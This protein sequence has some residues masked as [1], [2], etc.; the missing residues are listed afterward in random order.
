MTEKS[1]ANLIAE[2]QKKSDVR[3]GSFS[4]VARPVESLSTSNLAIDYVT[5]IGGLPV[6]RLIELYGL[7]SSGK[8]TTS[9]QAAAALQQDIIKSG[10]EEYILYLDFEHSLDKMYSQAL[11]LDSEHKSFILVQPAWVEDGAEIALS[12]IETGQVRL[13]IWDSVAAM[14]PKALGEGDFDQRTSAMNRARLMAGLLQRLT[15][16]LYD[17]G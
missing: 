16:L 8:S 5:G 3:I 1:V 2:I 13:S 15:A 14:T 6:G 4:D 17:H 10:R 11:G 7:A 12:L 9:T